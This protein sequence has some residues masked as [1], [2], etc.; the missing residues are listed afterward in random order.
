MHYKLNYNA[1]AHWKNTISALVGWASL[2]PAKGGAYLYSIYVVTLTF[3]KLI[4]HRFSSLL[5]PLRS[6]FE[7]WSAAQIA[8]PPWIKEWIQHK[9][10]EAYLKWVLH[11]IQ[12]ILFQGALCKST[13]YNILKPFFRLDM[14]IQNDVKFLDENSI[15]ICMY[16]VRSELFKEKTHFLHCFV[17]HFFLIHTKCTGNERKNGFLSSLNHKEA[18]FL[19]NTLEENL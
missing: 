6:V 7:S 3:R 18:V 12:R 9:S 17:H 2:V 8:P 1:I 10:M 11:V 14:K 13:I 4:H 15:I 5:P 19:W 16:Y